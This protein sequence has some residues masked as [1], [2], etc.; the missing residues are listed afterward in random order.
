MSCI[1]KTSLS[2]ILFP[3]FE[4]LAIEN[5]DFQILDMSIMDR[6]FGNFRLSNFQLRPLQRACFATA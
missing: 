5:Y 4:K 6:T 2:Q 3:D 1:G